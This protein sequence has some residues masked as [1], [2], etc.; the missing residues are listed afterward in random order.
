MWICE[1]CKEDNEDI[2]DTCYKCLTFPEEGVLKL[3]E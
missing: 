3:K 2:F 1:K